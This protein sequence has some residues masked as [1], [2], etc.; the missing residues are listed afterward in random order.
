MMTT[1][2]SRWI[3]S[4]T[5]A[6]GAATAAFG[7]DVV[8]PAA[9]TPARIAPDVFVLI[10]PVVTE[11]WP[12]LLDLVNVPA[13]LTQAQPGQCVRFGVVASGD[14]H[15][16]LLAGAR[17]VIS[18]TYNGQTEEFKDATP[19]ILKRLKPTG[20]DFVNQA[21]SVIGRAAPVESQATMAVPNARW[22]ASATGSDS[23]ASITGLVAPPNG[24]TIALHTRSL[25]V[26]TFESVRQRPSFQNLEMVSEWMQSYHSAPDP[27]RLL[28]AIR[29]VA[30]DEQ[31]KWRRGQLAFFTTALRASPA[32]AAELLTQLPKESPATRVHAALLLH[33][34]DYDVTPLMSGLSAEGKALVQSVNLP[35]PFDMTPDSELVERLDMLLGSFSASGRLEPLRAVA[36]MLAWRSEAEEIIQMIEAGRPPSERTPT[37]VRGLAYAAAGRALFFLSSSDGLAADYIEALKLAPATPDSVKRELTSLAANA[38]G[39]EKQ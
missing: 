18:L 19:L 36:S 14:A 4:L 39:S 33:L 2:A 11:Q 12:A 6:L 22:C 13:D 28:P 7:Q 29:I 37:V 20:A 34:A 26:P 5:V 23:A 10:E 16:R 21:L 32:A 38:M 17:V 9:P 30:A 35:D 15:G 31:A 27:A 8:E 25:E 1:S 3:V 24:D